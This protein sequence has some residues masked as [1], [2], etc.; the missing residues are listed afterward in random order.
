MKF[1]NVPILELI[2]L[3]HL[4]LDKICDLTRLFDYACYKSF[5]SFGQFKK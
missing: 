2:F 3:I 5:D 4:S 1:F